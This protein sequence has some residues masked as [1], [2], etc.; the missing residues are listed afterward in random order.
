M[1]TTNIYTPEQKRVF[2]RAFDESLNRLNTLKDA[3][4]KNT[5]SKKQFTGFV[6]E[7]LRQLHEKIKQILAKIKEFKKQVND[8]QGKV[9]NNDNGIRERDAKIAEL[10]K[11]LQQLIQDREKLTKD[12]NE[13]NQ[14]ANEK[15]AR[16]Q[17]QINQNETK[18]QQFQAQNTELTNQKNALEQELRNRGDVGAQHAQEIQKLTD[19]QRANIEKMQQENAARMLELQQQLAE[20]EAQ[21]QKCKEEMAK[22]QKMISDKE[23]E[24]EANKEQMTKLLKKI[25]EQDGKLADL[26]QKCS[27]SQEQQQQNDSAIAEVRNRIAQLEQE[28]NELQKENN[29]LIERIVAATNAIKSAT[30]KLEELTDQQ[31]YDQS[32]QN[33]SGIIREIEASLEEI[34]NT[35]QGDNVVNSRQL[36]PPPPVRL[37]GSPPENEVLNPIRNIRTTPIQRNQSVVINH[38]PWVITDLL[39]ALRSKTSGQTGE[40][41]NNNKYIRAANEI[42]MAVSSITDL[43]ALQDKIISILVDANIVTEQSGAIRGGKTNK[44]RKLTKTK[45][46]YKQKGG[47]LYGKYKKT[48]STPRVKSTKNASSPVYSSNSKKNRRNRSKSFTKRNR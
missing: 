28:K 22:L 46:N 38:H 42:E 16:L 9:N 32:N 45:K 8:L 3:I 13:A 6:I 20:K 12:L 1:A 15:S 43:Q 7:Q 47:F 25:E 19:E 48:A 33:I 40:S 24:L 14:K 11:E 30:E 34:S 18:L 27:T 35:I 10:T 26:E 44:L 17:E 31:F 23:G 37:R 36:P 4:N 29:Y 39:A 2:I 41:R 21:L 5:Q